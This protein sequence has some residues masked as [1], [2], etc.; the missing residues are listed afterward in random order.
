MH[1]KNFYSWIYAIG[2][3]GVYGIGY[4]AKSFPFGAW[5]DTLPLRAQVPVGIAA[6]LVT[7][8]LPF[9]AMIW[10]AERHSNA[11]EST[12]KPKG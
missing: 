3:L 10:L 4:L 1:T 5:F 7:L 6:I 11:P 8:V 2:V 12:P 9:A